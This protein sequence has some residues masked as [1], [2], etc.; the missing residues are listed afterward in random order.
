[1]ILLRYLPIVLLLALWEA[2][3]RFGWVSPQV[4]PSLTA[5][6][7]SWWRMAQGGELAAHGSASLLRGAA[8]LALSIVAG[9]AL[10]I[11]MAAFRP[12][13]TTLQPLVTFL[14]PLPKSALIPVIMIWMGLGHAAQITVIFLGCLLPVT[15]SAYNGAS[16]VERTLV[17]SAMSLG[18]RR[19]E[20][21]RHVLLPAALPEL[22]SGIR[23]ALA[24]A[25]VLLVSAEMVGARQGIGF[26]IS[27][28]GEGGNY[29]GMFAAVFTVMAFGFAADRLYLWASRR[30]LRW[31]ET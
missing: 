3:S 20:L 1:M 4:L 8:G 16:G 7:Q 18:A 29:P 11:A 31:R 19:S 27:F 17:W 30:L 23:I 6:G 24:L 22:L 14:Y 25:F 5:V 2:A 28:L 26:L 15:L 12:V 9:T 21:L 13:R 10:G